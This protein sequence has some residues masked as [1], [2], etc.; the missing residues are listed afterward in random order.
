VIA[1]ILKKQRKHF[2]TRIEELI[3]PS[4]HR[5][6]P[7]C[8]YFGVCGGCSWQ[9]LDYDQQLFWKKQHVED[10]LV[11]IGKLEI[12]KMEETLPAA[13][14]YHYRN[15]MDFSFG[16][17]RWLTAEEIASADENINREFALGL[18]VPARFD[19][20]LDVKKCLI[21]T[22]LGEKILTSIRNAALKFNTGAHN[23]LER[24]GVL[25][26]LMVRTSDRTGEIMVLLVTDDLK[27]EAD[28]EFMNFYDNVFAEEVPEVTEIMHGINNTRNPVFRG[29]PRVIKGQ[30]YISEQ[31]LG[32]DYRISPLSFFQTN[33]SQLDRFIQSILDYADLSP[34]DVL[35]DLYCGTGSITLPASK[36]VNRVFGVEMSESSIADAKM[37]AELNSIT[38]AEFICADLHA[39]NAPGEL[40][41]LPPPDVIII[42][43]PR[44]GMH[45]NL[46]SHLMEIEAE[47]FIYVSCNPTTQARDC[48]LMSEKYEVKKVLPVDM[49]PHTFHVESV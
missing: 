37:N 38:N 4:E 20:V 27:E 45:K 1:R 6:E 46:V 15:K 41:K 34:E 10:A 16:A 26:S 13:K 12:G 23:E 40:A 30:G 36:K 42:D 11:R 43:P 2:E 19:K 47:K 9:H 39:K 24:Q 5:V 48:E 18:H 21:H 14:Q 29:E 44:G 49:F 22:E 8:E 28:K 25:K 35:W 32:I 17:S 7:K 31:I 33:S 3:E